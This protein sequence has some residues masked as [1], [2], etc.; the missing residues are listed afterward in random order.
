MT[1]P[2]ITPYSGGVANPDGSQTQAEFTQNMFDQLS[3]EAE[4]STELNNTVDGINDTAIQV[5]VDANSAS[6]SA[7]AAEAAVSGLDYKGLWPDT[8]GS[9]NKGETW[10][11]QVS[12]TPTGQY[13]TALQNTTVDPVGDDV[14]W[15]GVVS[16]QSLGGLSNYQAGSIL[17]VPTLKPPVGS[18]VNVTSRLNALFEIVFGGVPNGYDVIN[19]G[20]GNTARLQ[21]NGTYGFLEYFGGIGGGS[22]DTGAILAMIEWCNNNGKIPF[23]GMESQCLSPLVLANGIVGIKGQSKI[24]FPEGFVNPEASDDRKLFCVWNKN[25]SKIYDENTADTF[26]IHGI[27]WRVDMLDSDG[28]INAIIGAANTDGVEIFDCKVSSADLVAAKPGARTCLSFYDAN[29]NM[30]IHSNDLYNENTRAGGGVIWVQGGS[31][32]NINDPQKTE[33]IRIFRNN[34]Y[35]TRPSDGDEAIALW[36]S[37]G[38]LQNVRVYENTFFLRGGGQGVTAFNTASEATTTG[39]I[40]DIKYERNTFY[41][42]IELNVIRLGGQYLPDDITNLEASD[43]RIFCETTND[44]TSYAIRVVQTG[45]DV[46]VDRNFIENVGAVNFSRGIAGY[47]LFDNKTRASGNTIKGGFGR[48]MSF[49]YSATDNNIDGAEWGL[50][51][52]VKCRGNELSDIKVYIAQF[53]GAENYEFVNNVGTMV[54]GAVFAIWATSRSTGSVNIK[55]NSITTNDVATRSVILQGSGKQRVQ[56]NTF[57]GTGLIIAASNLVVSTDNDYYG[58]IA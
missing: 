12:G 39:A 15:R 9:A 36:G 14:N 27:E 34:I 58:T 16:S 30:K 42:D 2:K 32:L 41:A 23:T 56:I 19:A 29:K 35:Q 54:S 52:C 40:D 25:Y 47:G 5:D 50:E 38:V 43:N 10:Q 44:S 33:N 8:G 28:D 48:G 17:D 20:N 18:V 55:A 7:A 53:I 24:T 3:Y 22:D 45:D 26:K 11:T 6:Q 4:L 1:I 13:F 37:G 46:I 51:E 57:D 49:V 21:V 31:G